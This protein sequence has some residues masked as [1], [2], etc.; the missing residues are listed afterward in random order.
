MEILLVGAGAIGSWI[1]ANLL[2]AG[3]RVTF[4]GRAPFVDAVRAGGLRASLPDG[5][6]WEFS[7]AELRAYSSVSDAVDRS[8]D[9]ALLCVK[10]YALDAALA[11]L[12]PYAGRIG[13]VVTF[14]NGVGSEERAAERF[15]ADRVTAATLTSPVS[16]VGPGEIALDR[17][18][19]GVGLADW[20]ATRGFA[21]RMRRECATPQMPIEVFD[22]AR[23]MK[24]S[25]MLLNIVGNAA[26][27][28]FDRD[29]GAIY[30]DRELFALEMRMVRECLAVMRALR[31]PVIDLPGYKARAFAW[32]AGNLPNVAAQLMLARR[33]A[34]GR[35]G[36]RPSFYYDVA[37]LTGRSEI[38]A[39]NGRIAD[40]AQR[41]GIAAP[42]N[43]WL[44][45]ELL[46]RV[47]EP[48]VTVPPR[49]L[50]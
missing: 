21:E 10:T 4:V 20:G 24:W 39:L 11:E 31:I 37:H 32:V 36:K 46:R 45:E 34:R 27:A 30:A 14:Q 12:Q 3:N 16:A 28:L 8:Y 1:G 38:G 48:G 33:V 43:R 17:L 40:E 5:A 44:T 13:R 49:A 2:R 35:G 47:R 15:G 29:V 42:A 23:A 25:K 50:R 19:G 6:R 41:L 7:P 9:A 26:S 18:G 22:D